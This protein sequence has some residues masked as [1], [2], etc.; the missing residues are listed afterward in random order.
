LIHSKT[1][2][3]SGTAA[4]TPATSVATVTT[5]PAATITTA[6]TTPTTA[7]PAQAAP[8]TVVKV[9]AGTPKINFLGKNSFSLS[10][11]Y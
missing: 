9:V 11:Y 3:A 10:L 7:A 8:A 5:T 2:G 1:P 6:T 4:A